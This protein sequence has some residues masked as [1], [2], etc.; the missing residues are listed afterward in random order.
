MQVKPVFAIVLVALAAF[1]QAEV[2]VKSGYYEGTQIDIWY[3]GPSTAATRA[4]GLSY[5]TIIILPGTTTSGPDGGSRGEIQSLL[6]GGVDCPD[7]VCTR[8]KE[9][10]AR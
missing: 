9:N 6:C 8:G 4:T 1:C 2:A 10:N 7:V 3:F 5:D